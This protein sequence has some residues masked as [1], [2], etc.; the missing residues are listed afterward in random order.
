MLDSPA[1]DLPLV[2]STYRLKNRGIRMASDR[3]VAVVPPKFGEPP[4]CRGIEMV[5]FI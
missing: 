2:F 3:V 1:I 5:G 4:C